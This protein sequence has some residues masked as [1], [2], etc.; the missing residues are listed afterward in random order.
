MRILLCRDSDRIDSHQLHHLGQHMPSE[1]RARWER[2]RDPRSARAMVVT[3]WL[4]RT[5][6]DR[7]GGGTDPGREWIIGYRG[8][9]SLAAGPHF[10]VAH[11]DSLVACVIADG[12]VGLDIEQ[13]DER[14]VDAST[15][16]MGPKEL[17]RIGSAADPIDE[18]TRLWVLKESYVKRSGDGLSDSVTSIDVSTPRADAVFHAWRDCGHWL[19]VCHGVS[20]REALRIEDLSVHDL[21][22]A[23]RRLIERVT[24]ASPCCGQG[25]STTRGYS[26]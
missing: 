16:V 2:M 18:A 11:S 25:Q 5:G 23:S 15:V 20:S 13:I 10:S 19:A 4:A 6:L 12:P 7:L 1:R 24:R 17:S 9:P 21:S 8:K 26:T 14:V 3:Y 22:T